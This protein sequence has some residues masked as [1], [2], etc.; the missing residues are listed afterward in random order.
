MNILFYKTFTKQI[1]GILS[2][3]FVKKNP[4]LREEWRWRSPAASAFYGTCHKSFDHVLLKEE[5]HK[6]HR[7]R[8]DDRDCVY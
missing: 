1:C 7:D 2:N 6:N 4:P 3:R 5:E 8:T